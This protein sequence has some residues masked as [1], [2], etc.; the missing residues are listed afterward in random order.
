MT[1]RALKWSAV[2]A[3]VVGCKSS[4]MGTD[5][6]NDVSLRMASVSTP[7]ATCYEDALKRDRKLRGRMVLTFST[8]PGSGKFTGVSIVENEVRDTALEQCVIGHVSTLTL[9]QPTK[10]SVSITY[11]LNFTPS[12]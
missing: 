1:M 7:I 12:N 9:A 5:V 4:G 3:A 2:L 10:T 8:A 6:R 11:P